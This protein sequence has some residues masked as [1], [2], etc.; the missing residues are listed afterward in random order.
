MFL[1]A[2]P[3]SVTETAAYVIVRD[4]AFGALL[5]LAIAA[6]VALIRVLLS[7]QDKRIED[8]Q[9]I[10]KHVEQREERSEKLI[11]KMTSAL[12][13]NTL[14]LERLE[15]G[16]DERVRALQANSEATRAMRDTM[17][18]VIRDYARLAASSYGRRATPA[19][20]TTEPPKARRG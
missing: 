3:Q 1:A 14:A 13:A 4:S 6:V 7:V 9:A 19:P 8:L 17:D 5:L 10:N 16:E 20:D 18:S 15:R 12:N 2:V 11:E